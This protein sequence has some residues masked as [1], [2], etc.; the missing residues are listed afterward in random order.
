MPMKL[1]SNALKELFER[2]TFV[3]GAMQGGVGVLLAARMGYIAVAEN[4]K[5]EMEAESNRVNLVLIPPRR[6]WIIDRYGKP[7]YGAL[8]E[9]RLA[10]NLVAHDEQVDVVRALAHNV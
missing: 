9:G 4:E 8:A 10:D 3:V 5:Y 6:G 1:S 2:R 7:I